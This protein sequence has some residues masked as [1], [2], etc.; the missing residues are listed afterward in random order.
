MEKIISG[1]QKGIEKTSIHLQRNTVTLRC[2]LALH[3][4][5]VICDGGNEHK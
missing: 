5:L 4:K 3:G 2:C 1:L